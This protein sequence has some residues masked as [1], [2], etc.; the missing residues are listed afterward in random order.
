MNSMLFSCFIL[1]SVFINFILIIFLSEIS[2]HI[3]VSAS[4]GSFESRST[5]PS[6]C[7]TCDGRLG[8]FSLKD[9][10]FVLLKIL[11]SHFSSVFPERRRR[12]FSIALEH[13]CPTATDD[14]LFSVVTPFVHSER[15]PRGSSLSFLKPWSHTPSLQITFSSSFIHVSSDSF[16]QLCGKH[17]TYLK[18]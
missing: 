2:F 7:L 8:S 6:V 15:P 12:C 1:S 5:Y 13:S 18:E 11:G 17:P 10:S 9:P 3:H 4:F 16:V 14:T